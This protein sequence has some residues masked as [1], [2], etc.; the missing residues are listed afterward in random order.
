VNLKILVAVT[1]MVDFNVKVHLKVDNSGVDTANVKM[2][3]NPLDEIAVEEAVRLNE[4]CVAAEVIA[5]SCGT[6]QCQET[7]RTAMAIGN[8]TVKAATLNTVTAAQKIGGDAH[9]LIAGQNAQGA[10]DA[11]AIPGAS[12]VLLA[13]AP[14]REAGLAENVEATV[15]SIAKNYSHILAPATAAGKKVTPR[16]A[17]KLDV[18]QIS[19]VTAA[20][21]WPDTFERPIYAGNAI[22]TVQSQD[23]NKMVAVRTTAL[24]AVAAE[25]GNAAVERIEAAT[26]SGP[27]QFVG[28]EVT[29]LDRPEL[30]RAKIIVSGG[31]GLGG[32][33]NYTKV[34]EPLADKLNAARSSGR[35]LR[36]GRLPGRLDQQD[37]RAAA[38][39]RGGHLGRNPAPCG[40][41]GFEGNRGDQQGRRSADIQRGRLWIRRRFV[42]GRAGARKRARLT[43]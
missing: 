3:M 35:R 29:T 37:R 34:L 38:L 13:D 4:K 33:E 30:A 9:V 16:I 27:S 39:H 17:A 2:S 25:G 26:D 43:H 19:D 1:R 40:H 23:H 24:D 15:Q 10:A 31:R 20:V 42:H 5:V 8:E 41:E 11:G 22:A 36:A 32:G 21:S 28:R 18:A 7:L 6:A 12:N 14:Q